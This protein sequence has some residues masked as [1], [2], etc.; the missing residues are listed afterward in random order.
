MVGYT[1]IGTVD[2]YASTNAGRASGP[3]AAERHP[4]KATA[5]ESAHPVTRLV[6][7]ESATAGNL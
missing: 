1:S 4:P 7:E 3:A 5:P 2:L 6:M